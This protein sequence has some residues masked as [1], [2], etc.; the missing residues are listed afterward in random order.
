MGAMA[1]LLNR[2]RCSPSRQDYSECSVKHSAHKELE[3]AI[4][5]YDGT[6]AGYHRIDTLLG[7]QGYDNTQKLW[8]QKRLID[9]ATKQNAIR[10]E[11]PETA[12]TSII[13]RLRELLLKGSTTLQHNAKVMQMI[14]Y[15][16]TIEL[17]QCILTL[18]PRLNNGHM[19]SSHEKDQHVVVANAYP[20][21]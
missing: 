14:Q 21:L 8:L 10:I 5:Q 6:V 7:G 17:V 12:D 3:Q 20:V 11:K 1:S 15:M 4:L 18:D 2:L 19:Q 9:V 16:T 13:V